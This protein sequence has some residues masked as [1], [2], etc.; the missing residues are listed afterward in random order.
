MAQYP[1]EVDGVLIEG[2]DAVGELFAGFCQSRA[3]GGLEGLTFTT[4]SSF[5]VDGCHFR[6]PMSVR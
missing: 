4:L 5:P 6:W 3:E 1:D 2:R